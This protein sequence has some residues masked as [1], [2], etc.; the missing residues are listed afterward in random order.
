MVRG[1]KRIPNQERNATNDAM[2]IPDY[3]AMLDG[4]WGWS[5]WIPIDVKYT[6]GGEDK[7]SKLGMRRPKENIRLISFSSLG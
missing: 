4:C 5:A 1:D 6:W 2:I 3:A 7:S